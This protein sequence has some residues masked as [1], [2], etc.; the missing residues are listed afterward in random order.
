MKLRVRLQEGTIT[1]PYGSMPR[2][3]RLSFGPAEGEDPHF[4]AVGTTPGRRFA[5]VRLTLD[6]LTEEAT[7]GF[8]LGAEY[9]L[10]LEP[11]ARR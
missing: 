10:T 4:V 5:V 2:A 6:Q 7:A 9:V 8:D 1:A 11:I 3:N